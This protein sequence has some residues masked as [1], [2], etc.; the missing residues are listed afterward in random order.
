MCFEPADSSSGRRLY[1]Q[2]WYCTFDMHKYK[3][4]LQI[5]YTHSFTYQTAYTEACKTHY[6]I[7]VYTTLPE[8]ELAGSNHVEDIK[9]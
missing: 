3:L 4:V 1:V 2:L 6:S 9:N 8:D 5:L 7:P